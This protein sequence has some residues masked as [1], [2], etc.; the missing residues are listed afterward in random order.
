MAHVP[1]WSIGR[2]AEL[3]LTLKQLSDNKETPK[4][5]WESDSRSTQQSQNSAPNTYDFS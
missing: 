4:P 2:T 3:K 1:F 5:G